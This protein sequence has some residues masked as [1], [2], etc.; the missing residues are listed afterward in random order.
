MGLNIDS[1]QLLL[2]IF[3]VLMLLWKPFVALFVLIILFKI[4]P[5][6][7]KI[8]TLSNSGISDI[9][10]MGGKIFEEYLEVMFKKLN[11]K[12]LRTKY[13]GDYGADLIIKKMNTK[14]LHNKIINDFKYK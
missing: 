11:Y 14:N 5:Y 8:H 10:V 9:D 1:T 2:T 13:T 3:N 6:F 4:I 7:S 12:V